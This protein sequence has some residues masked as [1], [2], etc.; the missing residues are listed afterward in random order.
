VAMERTV[1]AVGR[2]W[3]LEAVAAERTFSAWPTYINLILKLNIS[4]LVRTVML[5]YVL[6]KIH[7]CGDSKDQICRFLDGKGE[8]TTP[9][10]ADH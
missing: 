9:S 10:G 6:N 2:A 5:L 7:T 4:D 1:L 3:W 8:K